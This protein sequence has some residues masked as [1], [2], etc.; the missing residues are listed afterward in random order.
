MAMSQYR[1][2]DFADSRRAI[3]FGKIPALFR[4]AAMK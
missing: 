1:D 3:H 2:S 4:L